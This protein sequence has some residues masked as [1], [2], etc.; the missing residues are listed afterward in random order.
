MGAIEI[1]RT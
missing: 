1:F